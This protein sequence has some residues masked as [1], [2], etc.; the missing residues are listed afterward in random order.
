M[1][2]WHIYSRIRELRSLGL[3]AAQ[4]ARHVGVNVKTVYKY[5]E[6]D[7]AGYAELIK[8][9]ASH[10]SQ[11][12]VYAEVIAAWL[13]EFTDL[14]GAQI[15]DWLR[16]R[17]PD[18]KASERNVRR[19]VARLRQRLGIE[20]NPL[21]RQYQAVPDPPFAQQLQVDLGVRTKTWTNLDR[22]SSNVLL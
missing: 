16:E 13:R 18:C 21:K 9:S 8:T 12:D 1:V 14:S 7:A 10:K 11:L 6:I 3:N 4:I 17:Y 20:K 22:R 5:W 15:H 19:Y 2:E